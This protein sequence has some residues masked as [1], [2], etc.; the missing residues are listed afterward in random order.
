[1]VGEIGMRT[2]FIIIQH[3]DNDIAFQRSQFKNIEDAVKKG[4][5]EGQH[6][7]MLYDRI[8][9]NAGQPQLY[10]TQFER[11]DVE[12][13]IAELAP[14]ED[15]GN[16]DKRRKELDMMPIEVYKEFMIGNIKRSQK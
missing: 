6:F 9:I 2:V 16:L 11:I 8:K 14:V 12:N 7:A 1:M 10:G 5:L 3:S 13:F 15:I 4:D